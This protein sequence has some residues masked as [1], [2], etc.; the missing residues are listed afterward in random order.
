[1]SEVW[2]SLKKSLH[3]KPHSTEVHD[4]MTSRR[5]QQH[6]RKKTKQG[7]VIEGSNN[8][9]NSEKQHSRC[10]GGIIH[11]R[12]THDIV[13]DAKSGKIKICPCH[14]HTQEEDGG[15][16]GLEGSSN[17]ST[18]R[19]MSLT[20]TECVDCYQCNGFLKQRAPVHKGSDNVP[21]TSACHRHQCCHIQEK[22]ADE[23]HSINENSAV[24]LD[25]ED[26]SWKIIER[27]CQTKN[28]NLGTEI[29]CVLKVHTTAKTLASFE[30]CRENVR[31]IVENMQPRCIADGNEVMRFHGTTIAC[32]LGVVNYPSVL[33][34]LEPCGLCQI[35]RHGFK[36]NQELFHGEHGVLTTATSD[37]A[38]DSIILTESS[39]NDK[40]LPLLKKCVIV[41]RVI[42]GRVHNPLQEIQEETDSGFDSLV[43]K[44]SSDSDIE[45]LFILKPGAILPC[46]VPR[47][48]NQTLGD[49]LHSPA[50][51]ASASPP[52]LPLSLSPSAAAAGIVVGGLVLVAAAC[53]GAAAVVILSAFWC[54]KESGD[55]NFAFS[56]SGTKMPRR[57]TRHC[58]RPRTLPFAFSPFARS[59]A[60]MASPSMPKRQ[61]QHSKFDE[62]PTP[63]SKS[64]LKEKAEEY[65]SSDEEFEGVVQA[66]FS[67][68][69]PK[70]NDFHGVKT[71]LQTY[72]DDKE[73]DL[74]GFVDLILAQTT[75]GTV[76]KI[77][78]DEDEGLFAVVSAL[79]LWRYREQKCITDVKEF[80]LS[81][82]HQEKGIA[83]KLRLLLEEQARDIGI[84]VSQRVLNLP[85]QLLPH[86]YEALFDEVS[87]ATEDEVRCQWYQIG[88]GVKMCFYLT[89]GD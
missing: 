15:N 5:R 67:F 58:Q 33:C 59:L 78:D 52:Y 80:L 82:A 10:L 30:E 17:A 2:S 36:A 75:V 31:N 49:T 51:L 69:D 74:S 56:C 4:P 40:A 3:C 38:L 32:S 48:L 62:K 29:E 27:I 63:P 22:C 16:K 28:T 23:D 60:R 35:L 7:K 21:L 54:L 64:S 14:P 13:V 39:E 19:A 8:N 77:E 20:K 45:Q 61:Q 79:N 68:F 12:V 24:Q 85:P 89:T 11:D 18:R 46:F 53:V 42:A 37:Q 26:L 47:T 25:K 55:F 9:N 65:E 71:L 6:H 57:P 86:L 70:P 88:E 34:T 43:K 81:K 83:D 66:D 73:W 50:V 41:C 76:V 84:L 87:W 72:L 1:M 44:I